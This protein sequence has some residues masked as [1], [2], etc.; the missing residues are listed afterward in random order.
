MRGPIAR[1]R[2]T[3]G[4]HLVAGLALGLT[5]VCWSMLS[6]EALSESVPHT[7]LLFRRTLFHEGVNDGERN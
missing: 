5:E 1:L 4:K 6:D 7:R 2:K 3:D